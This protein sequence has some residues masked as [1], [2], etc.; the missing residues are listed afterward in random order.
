[1]PTKNTPVVASASSKKTITRRH[2]SE[3]RIEWRQWR[4]LACQRACAAC[5]DDP[6][7][8][9]S[10][11]R[12]PGAGTELIAVRCSRAH[13]GK[14]VAGV[15]QGL[16]AVQRL[17]LAA[18]AADQDVDGARVDVLCRL[19]AQPLEDIVA[20][21]HLGRRLREHREQLELGAGQLDRA[22]VALHGAAI[23]VDREAAL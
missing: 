23:E 8:A 19:A 13:A 15:A 16:D 21:E 18:Q 2:F 14:G 4:C 12:G 11:S 1:M 5:H 3:W 20:A 9:F 22:A 6:R 17:E 7:A 10:S